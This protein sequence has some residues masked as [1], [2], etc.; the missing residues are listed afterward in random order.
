MTYNTK[1]DIELLDKVIKTDMERSNRSRT[2]DGNKQHKK[3]IR[4]RNKD[5]R[6]NP[7]VEEWSKDPTKSDIIGIDN[8][9][10]ERITEARY[11][12][13]L[14]KQERK[15]LK[16]IRKKNANRNKKDLVKDLSSNEELVSLHNWKKWD[17]NKKKYDIKNVDT[18]P[19]QV[20]GYTSNVIRK[21]HI[22]NV[23]RA[24]YNQGMSINVGGYYAPGFTKK[25]QK[26][27][28]Y[29]RINRLL[30]GSPKS[31]EVLAHE[32]GHAFEY[33][34]FGKTITKNPTR[35][36]GYSYK[37]VEIP[38]KNDVVYSQMKKMAIMTKPIPKGASSHFVRYRMKKEE[39]FADAFLGL[40]TDPKRAKKIAP[41]FSRHVYTSSRGLSRDIRN[42]RESFLSKFV[43]DMK[44]RR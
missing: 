29:I 15:L 5:G 16:K 33:N 32:M 28:N 12:Q 36:D 14:T 27:R 10:S 23:S 19:H 17:R 24:K 37:S 34:L 26:P 21:K 38:K 9:S 43:D 41:A 13:N 44:R 20:I 7:E 2:V 3:Q 31:Q 6:I 18:V 4:L 25:L 42:S 8:V 11:G 35:L 22:Q 39:L 40:V 30:K 1:K